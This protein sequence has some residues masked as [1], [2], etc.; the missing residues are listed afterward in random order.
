MSVLYVFA[1][2]L[3][4]CSDSSTVSSGS[5][6]DL[7]GVS[8]STSV[9]SASGS[10]IHTIYSN[11][12]EVGQPQSYIFQLRPQGVE[13]GATTGTVHWGDNTDTRIRDD[14]NIVVLHTYYSAGSYKFAVQIDGEEK[15]VVGTSSIA[16]GASASTETS[17][18]GILTATGI[19]EGA[20]CINARPGGVPLNDSSE[21]SF[22]ATAP[23]LT[24]IPGT[25][26]TIICSHRLAPRLSTFSDSLFADPV[27]FNFL[28]ARSDGLPQCKVGDELYYRFV[29][30]DGARP[31]EFECRWGVGA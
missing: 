3:V 14:H 6:S 23:Q 27:T 29:S 20:D 2:L 11:T 18:F 10:V 21:V 9:E 24:G 16:T 15:V 28:N 13:P 12:G 22:A 8:K 31:G 30:T 19:F 7:E 1:A 25:K 4:G 26:T 5:G 17:R